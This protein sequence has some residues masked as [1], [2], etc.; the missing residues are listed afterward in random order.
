MATNLKMKNLSEV[1]RNIRGVVDNS[2]RG[3]VVI[4]RH[5]RPTAI[6]FGV[7]SGLDA[8]ELIAELTKVATSEGQPLGIKQ[9]RKLSEVLAETRKRQK[10]RPLKSHAEVVALLGKG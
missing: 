6:L 7:E 10:G 5:G 4:Q 1:R 3:P 9:I 2:Q 8:V